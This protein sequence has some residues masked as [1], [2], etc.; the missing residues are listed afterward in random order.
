MATNPTQHGPC[1]TLAFVTASLAP[2]SAKHSTRRP[3]QKRASHPVSSG[4]P[5]RCRRR[6]RAR[7]CSPTRRARDVP[8]D[9]SGF[10]ADLAPTEARIAQCRSGLA[11]L[12]SQP[13]IHPRK[14][15]AVRRIDLAALETRVGFARRTARPPARCEGEKPGGQFAGARDAL[16]RGALQALRNRG[17]EVLGNVRTQCPQGRRRLRNDPRQTSP[18]SILPERD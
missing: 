8:V 16:L 13:D 12:S 7:R 18:P 17:F 2:P 9:P 10:D 11:D 14:A 6:S 3:P 1:Q 15:S 4:G 5:R